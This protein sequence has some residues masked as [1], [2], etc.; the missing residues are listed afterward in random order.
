MVSAIV[1]STFS[2]NEMEMRCRSHAQRGNHGEQEQKRQQE[3]KLGS[4]KGGGLKY[5]EDVS[6]VKDS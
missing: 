2:A 5:G 4:V 6:S 3:Y 1:D